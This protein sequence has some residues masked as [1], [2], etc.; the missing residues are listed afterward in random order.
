MSIPLR[1]K[2]GSYQL[3]TFLKLIAR[4]RSKVTLDDQRKISEVKIK[5]LKFTNCNSVVFLNCLH[6]ISKLILINPYKTERCKFSH[7]R[8]FKI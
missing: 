7:S 1:V 8:G 5:G 6:D 3:N 4:E 2:H